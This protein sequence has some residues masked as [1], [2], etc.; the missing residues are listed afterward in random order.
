MLGKQEK[1]KRGRKEAVLQVQEETGLTPESGTET[2]LTWGPLGAFPS[3][4]P[5]PTSISP[6]KGLSQLQ[7]CFEHTVVNKKDVFSKGPSACYELMHA[8]CSA[9]A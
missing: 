1:D 8:L 2:V 5:P 9:R 3:L 6:E 4:S 7:H